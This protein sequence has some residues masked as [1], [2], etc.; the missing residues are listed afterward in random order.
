MYEK[1]CMPVMNTIANCL[2][3][4]MY[5]FSFCPN[6]HNLSSSAKSVSVGPRFGE[7]VRCTPPPPAPG[8]CPIRGRLMGFISGHKTVILFDKKDRE[9]FDFYGFKGPLFFF[10]LLV[11]CLL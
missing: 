11:A 3:R 4:A 10:F 7:L 9:D 8:F 1:C 6:C 2:T 5:M